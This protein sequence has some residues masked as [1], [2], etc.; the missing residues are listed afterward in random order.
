MIK[1]QVVLDSKLSY[2]ISNSGFPRA[3]LGLAGIPCLISPAPLSKCR[4]VHLSTT[5]LGLLQGQIWAPDLF[6]I[7][8]SPCWAMASP[9]DLIDQLI[10]QKEE[11]NEAFRR[12]EWKEA[13]RRYTCG[14]NAALEA[15]FP[16]LDKD[17]H[18]STPSQNLDPWPS[19]GDGGR[20]GAFT[21][22]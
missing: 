14:I 13:L 19:K 5:L 17:Q 22:A 12:G 3:T 6:T 10:S 11:G 18:S 15:G 21:P 2:T 9:G 1:K 8:T 4:S 7:P 20:A 16:G